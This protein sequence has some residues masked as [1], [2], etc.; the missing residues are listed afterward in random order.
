MTL[1]ELI[2]SPKGEALLGMAAASALHFGSYEFSR[3]AIIAMFTSE[4]TGFSS[5]GAM[6][7]AIVCIGPFSL[8]LLWVGCDS[9]ARLFFLQR[10]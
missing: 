8:L 5:D 7:F 2:H 3:S 6:P 4:K 9:S 1:L 10:H